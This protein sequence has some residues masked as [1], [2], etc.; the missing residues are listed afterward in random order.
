MGSS[1]AK[2]SPRTDPPIR[3]LTRA[4]SCACLSARSPPRTQGDG[5]PTT[6]Q[7]A[8]RKSRVK[9]PSPEP[10]CRPLPGATSPSPTSS[11]PSSAARSIGPSKS[12]LGPPTASTPSGSPRRLPGAAPSS[13]LPAKSALRAAVPNSKRR[14]PIPRFLGLLGGNPGEAEGARKLGETPRLAS[15]PSNRAGGPRLMGLWETWRS[16]AHERVRGFTVITTPP[17][18]LCAALHN[19]VLLPSLFGLER[20]EPAFDLSSAEVTGKTIPEQGHTQIA[21]HTAQVGTV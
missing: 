6:P 3:R 18:E 13:T 10:A 4:R 12:A 7:T 15:S 9:C 20:F 5:R 1:A 19:L 8:P 14:F 2:S 17:N 16:P 21:R 11:N